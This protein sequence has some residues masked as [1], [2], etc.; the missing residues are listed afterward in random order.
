MTLPMLDLY[1]ETE[2]QIH[3]I[4]G[5]AEN[6]RGLPLVDGRQYF[7]KI[8]GDTVSYADSKEELES[9]AGNNYSGDHYRQIKHVAEGHA[10]VAVNTHCDGNIFLYV[11]A[12][13][14]Q[15]SS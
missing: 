7:W 8:E 14:K 12:V 2:K 4:F 5:Y 15:V 13:E 3:S 9:G 10:L 6:W 11:F 1:W